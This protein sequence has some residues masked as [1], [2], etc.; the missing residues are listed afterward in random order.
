MIDW[1]TVLDL[2]KAARN[3]RTDAIGDWYRD[4]WGWPE[5]EWA[6]AAG[7][8]FTVGRLNAAGTTPVAKIDVPKENFATRPA[9]VLDPIDRLIY[10]ALVDRLSVRLAGSLDP[11]VYGWRL[12]PNPKV[13]GDYARN[14]FQYANFRSHL[15][16]GPELWEYSFSTDI[17]GFFASL[18]VER[19]CETIEQRAH[20]G[21]VSAR[22]CDLLESWSRTPGRTGIPQR[23][24]ASSLIASSYIDSVDMVLQAHIG[25]LR[26][27]FAPAA[28]WMDDTWVFSDDEGT[29]RRVQREL[30][31]AMRE[32]GLNMN[33]AKTEV[34]DREGAKQAIRDIEH[35][36]VDAGLAEDPPALGEF[37]HLLAS[38]TAQPEKASKTTIRFLAT[39]LR[40][41]Q[42]WAYLDEF[43][44]VAKRMP[45]AADNLT[46]MFRASA[47]WRDFEAWFREYAVSNWATSDWAVAHLA[48]MFP[49]NERPS[50][51]TVDFYIDH[52]LTSPSLAIST[53]AAQR[54]ASWRP[55]AAR[56]A[57]RPIVQSADNPLARRA[58][59]LTLLGAG[60]R[61]DYVRTLLGQFEANRVTLAMLEASDYRPVNL[62]ADY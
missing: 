16:Q 41:H 48:R 46:R 8:D 4:P 55:E 54:V 37:Q 21:R 45:H 31:S 50:T 33:A 47:R 35:S 30:E 39:R 2:G 57:I 58:F 56:A 3:V 62:N 15:S 17:V 1:L 52:L 25:A 34:Y 40:S 42:L 49:S 28:R 51:T 43:L 5:T 59:A 29:L 13:A 7:A 6:A 32:L 19:V 26:I 23:C 38:V 10:Q 20:D 9:I 36:A 60:E 44:Q 11:A 12:P 61:R 18:P 22:L 27:P 24:W 53:V 14:D